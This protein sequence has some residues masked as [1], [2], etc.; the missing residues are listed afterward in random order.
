MNLLNPDALWWLLLVPALVALYMLRPQPRPHTVSSLRLWEGLP[1]PARPQAV[2]RL[3]LPPLSLLLLVQ[4]L[5]L[6]LGT[7][8]LTRPALHAPPP[9]HL[10]IVLDASG[11]M[12]ARSPGGPTRF[13]Q[14]LAEARR[15]G[16]GM[17]DADRATLLRAGPMITTLCTGCSRP[18]L[19]RALAGVRVGAGH[20]DLRAALALAAGLTGTTGA[21]GG[22][23]GAAGMEALTVLISDGA[24]EPGAPAPDQ[25]PT[26]L[27][28]LPT[29]LRYVQVGGEG[30]AHNVALTT[31]A[32]RQ[33]PDGS[34]GYTALA[35]VANYTDSA[36]NIVVSA[37]ADTVPLSDRHVD[38]PAGGRAELVWTL[39]A[40]T[41]RFTVSLS[42]SDPSDPDMPVNAITT[43]D[44][45]VLFLP[46]PDG[47]AVVVRS[48]DPEP[49]MRALEGIPGLRPIKPEEQGDDPVAFTI[50]EGRLPDPLPAGGLLLVNPEGPLPGTTQKSVEDAQ[51]L[52]GVPLVAVQPTHPLLAGLDLRALIVRRARSLQPLDWLEALVVARLD[53]RASTE[54]QTQT[55][56]QAGAE[57][58]AEDLPLLMAG[59]HDERRIVV[60]AFD[61]KDSNLPELTAFP[62]LIANAADWLYPLAGVQALAPG[63]S[64]RLTPGS[65]V[66]APD[67]TQALVGP[68][69]LFTDTEQAGI[70]RVLEPALQSGGGADEEG[71]Q[72]DQKVGWSF[73][74][75][76]DGAESDPAPRPHPE[77]SGPGLPGTW[78][79]GTGDS[80]HISG[81]GTGPTST[82][83][84]TPLTVVVLVLI[85]GEWLLY[86]RKR[87]RA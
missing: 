31:L 39:P 43:D 52:Q 41:A 58:F 10:L 17:G 57:A 50:I 38:M 35:R 16:A 56:T 63:E 21:T 18:E 73:A 45:A 68:G 42:A 13:Q 37:L 48:P 70:Y 61:P 60:L 28:P 3:R 74:V 7:L 27:P 1:D 75:N 79:G 11:S 59:E 55:E 84:W 83:L 80:T 51:D 15:L 32:A 29:H 71:R 46:A 53:N 65:T 6:L 54:V 81:A 2:R 77:L 78:S 20:A 87:G 36:L 5:A 22:A 49:Y 85:I 86:Y 44:R 24:F 47:H 40:G 26:Q 25:G 9:R 30:D 62:L 34:P 72:A 69:G 23:T 19:E 4:A 14:A 67:G 82:E 8:A 76:M 12:Q 64:L 66:I 33:P